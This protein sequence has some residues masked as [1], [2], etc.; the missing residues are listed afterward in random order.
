[1]NR[2][3][4]RCAKAILALL[5]LTLTCSALAACSGGGN[6]AETTVPDSS[7]ESTGEQTPVGPLDHL[8]QGD[9]QNRYFTILTRD[10]AGT[11]SWAP[12]DIAYDNAVVGDAINDA[13][14]ERNELVENKY[15]VVIRQS[16]ETDP[17]TALRNSILNNLAAYDAA[18]ITLQKSAVIALE[19]GLYDLADIDAVDL[20]RE[21][22]DTAGNA[23]IS[24]G[25][26]TYFAMGDF[27]IVDDNAT[28]CVLFNKK[29]VSDYGIDDQYEQVN[30]GDWTLEAMYTYGARVARDIN[31][32]G[33]TTEDMWGVLEQNECMIAYLAG[34]GLL[35]VTKDEQDLPQYNFENAVVTDAIYQIHGLMNQR[36]IVLNVNRLDV[37]NQWT[38]APTMFTNN[39]ALYYVT[40]VTSIGLAAFRDMK[41]AFGILPT[42][43]LSSS[44][45]K[46]YSA[47]QGNN[48]TAVSI[49][50]TVSAEESGLIIEAMNAA[51]TDTLT[52]TYHD[53]LLQRRYVKDEESA[54]MLQLIFENR[55]ID[56]AFIFN[57]ADVRWMVQDVA[58]KYEYT[59]E[60]R[61]DSMRSELNEAIDDTIELIQ[62]LN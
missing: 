50:T 10:K 18:A 49:P 60:S 44:Q 43:K 39:Q 14:F 62:Q 53:T 22:W 20:S 56:T 26:R 47:M 17:E 40:P 36:E 59:Y 9:Y 21:Y 15:H 45:E 12:V 42:P 55:I 52:T 23:C 3:K 46:Y 38:V 37:S 34:A 58:S 24:L 51:S 5:A 54:S 7:G 33:M 27:N 29:L 16:E 6:L 57:W 32:D 48:G 1:M 13:V 11:T 2:K 61:I 28:W 4:N 31:N 8:P 25:G 30:Y 41:S 35:T 19:G